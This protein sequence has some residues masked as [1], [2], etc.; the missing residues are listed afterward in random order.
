MTIAM[1]HT[2]YTKFVVLVLKI[3]RLVEEGV[4][5]DEIDQEIADDYQYKIDCKSVY[6]SERAQL[7]LKAMSIAF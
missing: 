5:W 2:Q 1:T 7:S 3:A 6:E 4:E